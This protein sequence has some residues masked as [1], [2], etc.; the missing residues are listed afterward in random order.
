MTRRDS[1]AGSVLLS[2]LLWLAIVAAASGTGR[3]LSG[4]GWLVQLAVAVGLVLAVPAGARALRAHPVVPPILATLTAVVVVTAMFVPARSLLFV[5]PTP[6]ALADA[7]ALAQ[8]GFT[9]IAQQGLPAVADQGIAFLLVGG[10]VVLAWATD[11]FAFSVRL[12]A[13]AGLFPA[14]L[15]AVPAVID[16]ADVSWASLIVTTL[17]YV[18]IL[19]VS[20]RP[21]RPGASRPSFASAAPATAVVGVVVVVA[22]LLAGSASGYVRTNTSSGVSGTL[23][24]GS[25]D[26][27][28]A[29]GAD[30]RRPDPVTVLRYATDSDLPVYLRVLTVSDFEGENWAPSATE[31]TAPIDAPIVPEGLAD[32][33]PRLSEEVDVSVETLRSQWLPVP[34]PVESLSGV[35]DGWLQDVQD[36]SIRGDATTRAGDDYDVQALRLEPDPQQLLDA[37]APQG[38]DR[39]LTLPDDLPEIV[40]TTAEQVTAD[41][42][43]AYDRARS[44]QSYFRSSEF[45]YS[46]DTPAEEGYDGD[47]VG[48]LEAFLTVR[49]GYCVHFAS[50]MAVMARDLGI[51]SRLAIGYQPGSVVPAADSDLT[52][53]RVMSS[54]LHA[55]PE[56]YFEGVGWLP[57]EPTP[58]RGA[59]AS[60]T[61]PNATSS[62]GS[63]TPGATSSAAAGTTPE[64]SA[65]PTATA[66]TSTATAGALGGTSV[67]AAP[68][69][70]A[71]VLL[72]LVL[73]V[74]WL[75]RV[76]Q[77]A[78]RRRA[79]EGGSTEAAWTELLAS[80][81][82]L[83]VPVETTATPRAQEALIAAS[84]GGDEAREALRG[85]RRTL[86]HVRYAPFAAEAVSSWD[87]STRVVASLRTEVGVP[88]R[89]FAA[90]LPRS[91]F[92]PQRRPTSAL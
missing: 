1:R 35:G 34:Y 23:F 26:P 76:V 61:L 45:T 14:A 86:E 39:Y 30:L 64:A 41:D 87:A 19:A 59:P 10:V 17:L 49:E 29:L 4:V 13:L 11:L 82:D 16:P 66:A 56:L 33:V 55:W 58:S 72:L 90:V 84:L 68:A 7:R 21:R 25:I 77:R 91:A 27:V 24:N 74:P 50:A 43:T 47:G 67:S 53:Y 48:V 78:L 6:S 52:N 3:L 88:R 18:A 9:S 20:A 12:P 79:A 60:Y 28:V 70:T 22:G 44:L 62:S 63:S 81:R 40:R 75:L 73:L 80:A 54:D 38:L 31:E 37:P 65:A 51:P 46:E 92:T 57:F 32:S 89:V 85:L 8:A 2:V 5:I 42:T 36:G 83:G 15:L 69:V 71:W